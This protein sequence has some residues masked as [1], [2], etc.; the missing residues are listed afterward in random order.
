MDW[1]KTI[2]R[3]YD[4]GLYTKETE[5]TMYVGNFVVYGKITAEQYQAITDEQY[6]K[7]TE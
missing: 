4:M 3:Y 2:K 6:P 5:S 1:Y 7:A